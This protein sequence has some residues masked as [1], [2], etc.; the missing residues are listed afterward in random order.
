M[1]IWHDSSR[2]NRRHIFVQ[3]GDWARLDK[4]VEIDLGGPIQ[5][6][7]LF[8]VDQQGKLIDQTVNLQLDAETLIF[9]L[10]GNTPAHT[11]RHYQLYFDEGSDADD[12][13]AA[14]ALVSLTEKL[15][16]E[17]FASYR[18]TTQNATYYYHQAGAGFASMVD[19]DGNDWLSFH[20]FGGSDGKFRGIPNVVHPEGHFHPGNDGCISEIAAAGPLKVTINSRSKDD[21]WACTWAIYPT[22]AHLTIL[23]VDHPYWLLYEGTPGGELDEANDYM[24][25]SDGKRMA[26]SERWDGP[27]PDPEWIYFGAGNTER[28]LF[29]VQHEADQEIDSYWPM[30]KNMTVFGFGRKGLE[31]YMTRTPNHFT[32][33]FAESGE[34]DVAKATIEAAYQPVETGV[35]EIESN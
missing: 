17:G 34:F 16:H 25:R 11:T 12:G 3:S 35:G 26:A 21:K 8:E 7:R 1:T 10:K 13:P 14:P 5:R 15:M 29:L 22:Y 24:V 28:V 32:I 33:G 18:I 27:L 2:T 4:P 19:I 20:P 9:L 6:P 23:K 30:E 31:K